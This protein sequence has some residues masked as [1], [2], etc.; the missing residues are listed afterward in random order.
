[1]KHKPEHIAFV[2]RIPRT[3]NG[4]TKPQHIGEANWPEMAAHT[5]AKVAELQA[6]LD[7]LKP[8]ERG[9]VVEQIK[10]LKKL[11]SGLQKHVLGLGCGFDTN[12]LILA[13]ELDGES[14]QERCPSCGIW[15]SWTPATAEGI[16]EVLADE[17]A[18][19]AREDAEAE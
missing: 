15:I 6:R 8:S 19:K 4:P 9:P 7:D 10:E 14:R 1:M 5:A 13:H 16:D 12:E 3:C 18:E 17:T 11:H 2:R